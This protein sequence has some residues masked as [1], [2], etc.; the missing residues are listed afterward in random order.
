MKFTVLK[1]N[2]SLGYIYIYTGIKISA[3]SPLRLLRDGFHILANGSH[4]LFF[5]V[6]PLFQFL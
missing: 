4:T 6:M 3:I 1:N 2:K 5:L